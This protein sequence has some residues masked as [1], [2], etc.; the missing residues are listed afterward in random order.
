LRDAACLNAAMAPHG[1]LMFRLAHSV[2]PQ[3]F[4]AL[5]I[6]ERSEEKSV[7]TTSSVCD[8]SSTPHNPNSSSSS[9]SSMVQACTARQ[10]RDTGQGCLM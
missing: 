9:S 4:I 10:L 5:D 7:V 3:R 6:V 1:A 8:I 2:H